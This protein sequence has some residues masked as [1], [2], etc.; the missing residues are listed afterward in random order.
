MGQCVRLCEFRHLTVKLRPDFVSK[1]LTTKGRSSQDSPVAC[2]LLADL[3]DTAAAPILRAGYSAV[4]AHAWIRP[5]FGATNAALKIHLGLRVDDSDCAKMRVGEEWRGWVEGDTIIFDDRYSA[6]HLLATTALFAI[7]MVLSF[8]SHLRWKTATAS[9]TRSR[10][11][12]PVRGTITNRSLII[13]LSP[14]VSHDVL[15]RDHKC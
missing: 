13:F 5:H 9:S 2:R 3:R 14:G 6:S 4:D 7:S 12:V 15:T 1:F 10:T 11:S 8:A